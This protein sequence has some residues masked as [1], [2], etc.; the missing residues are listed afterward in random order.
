MATYEIDASTTTAVTAL[1]AGDAFI[2]DA[3][4]TVSTGGASIVATGGAAN[5]SFDIHGTL[6]STGGPA[7]DFGT[8]GTASSGNRITIGDEGRIGSGGDGIRIASTGLSLVNE[9]EIGARLVGVTASA[10]TRIT[11]SGAISA[12][13]TAGISASGDSSVVTNNGTVTAFGN[14]LV[15]TGAA[16]IATNNGLAE[17]SKGAAILS[18]GDRAI[19]TNN[20]TAKA[21]A[22]AVSV[23][24]EGATVTNNGLIQSL[25]D[26]GL[27]VTGD[28]AI[29]TNN[30]TISAKRAGITVTG[31]D[32]I[33][34]N[35]GGIDTKAVAIVVSADGVILRNN[36]TISAGS[37]MSV[38]GD[39]ASLANYGTLAGTL[40]SRAT[41]DLAKATAA[42]LQNNG[43]IE[44]VKTAV[45]GGAGS[46]SVVNTGTIRGHIDLGAGNDYL[47]NTGA[48]TGTVRG[49]KGDDV[50]VLNGNAVTIV[51]LRGGGNDVVKSS[52]SH[53][54]ADNIEQ[55]FLFGAR[56]IDGTGNASANRIE[57]NNAANRLD[58]GA[59]NDVLVGHRGN[60]TLTG[61][62]GVDTF[63]FATGHGRDTI[64]DF[65]AKGALHD[66]LDLTGLASITD[67]N[68]LKA[69]HLTVKG[70]D[71][72]INGLNGDSILLQ[73][74]A[75]KDLDAGDFWF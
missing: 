5:R 63:V 7:I 49:G 68:D 44:A 17:A 71:I 57:G 72:L 50:Y 65:R 25:N 36:Q 70:A 2:V 33:V 15:L 64:T 22:L 29:I 14:A 13:G 34:T 62:K 4:V 75:L 23:T 66:V 28:T 55:L 1:E 30:G 45:L 74:V 6:Q 73:N 3:G 43:L 52:A 16:I 37:A 11:N 58:G 12:G 24:G 51:E 48:I 47:E 18:R 61:G 40:A 54:L 53:V 20:G 8:A 59:G 42:A 38:T 35:D 69:D 27:S 31:D 21:A 32:T 60:D 46:Q 9:G 67:F 10:T 26:R 41:V 19:V 39:G 56:K